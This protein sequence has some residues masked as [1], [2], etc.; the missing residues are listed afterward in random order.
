MHPYP[1]L[2]DVQDLRRLY[3]LFGL[4]KSILDILKLCLTLAGMV[5]AMKNE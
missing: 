5:E 3:M 2:F 1:K 4:K